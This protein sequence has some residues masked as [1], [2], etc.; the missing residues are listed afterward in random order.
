[1]PTPHLLLKPSLQAVEDG[2]VEGEVS[3][4]RLKHPQVQYDL[5]GFVLCH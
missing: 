4:Q 3:V 1:M 5:P 2:P